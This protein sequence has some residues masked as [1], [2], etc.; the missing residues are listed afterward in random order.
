MAIIDGPKYTGP[1]KLDFSNVKADLVD[2]PPG[3][4]KGARA[5]KEGQADV[6]KELAE[7]M[8]DHGEAVGITAPMYQRYLD[9]SALLA[10]LRAHEAALSKALEVCTE[11]RTMVENNREETIGAMARAVQDTAHRARDEG[12][13]SPFEKLLRYNAQVADKAAQTRRKNAETKPGDASQDGDP[14]PP[15]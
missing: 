7:A 13:A 1:T 10:K 6:A 2:L 14:T 9:Q 4:M 3:G 8:A 12:L 15:A 5:E 11:T